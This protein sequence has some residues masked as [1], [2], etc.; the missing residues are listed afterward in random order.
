[1]ETE[2]IFRALIKELLDFYNSS[3]FFAIKIILGIY[4]LIL[5]IDIVLLVIQRGF[6]SNL[7]T[8]IL[9]TDMPVEFTTKKDKL[10]KR[11]GDVKKRLE[12][13]KESEYK[14]AVIEADAIIDDLIKRMGYAG[15]NLGER[16]AA[17]PIGQL[18]NISDMAEA[19]EIRNKIVLDG[20][21][22]ISREEAKK[23][24]EKFESLLRYFEVLD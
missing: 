2:I 17:V 24:L 12:A 10:R 8:S 4:A 16:L 13:E 22:E 20:S 3:A 7:R 23:T 1:M 6:S 18:E 15:G 11:W 14:V 19:H 9:G 21:F 5:F